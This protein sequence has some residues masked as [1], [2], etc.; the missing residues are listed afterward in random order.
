MKGGY[1]MAGKRYIIAFKRNRVN[2]R[3]QIW[4]KFNASSDDEAID[5]CKNRIHARDP[6][7]NNRLRYELLTGDWQ[8]IAD[9]VTDATNVINTVN[10]RK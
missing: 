7:V 3:R 8:H 1:L 10:R 2:A 4:T 6:A 5:I 9:M